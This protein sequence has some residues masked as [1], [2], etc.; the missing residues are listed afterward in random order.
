MR[1]ARPS[2]ASLP[3]RS[4]LTLTFALV[5]MSAT[6]AVSTTTFLLAKQYLVEQRERAAIRQTFLNARL[7]RDLLQTG[8]QEPQAILDDTVGE[9]GT[10]ALL[11]FDDQWFASGVAADP[12]DLPADLLDALDNGAA[13]HQRITRAG[14]PRVVIGVP[15]SA[16]NAEYLEIIPLDVLQ[17]TFRTLVIS[18]LIGSIGTTLA[19]TLVGVYVSQRVL[20][21]VKKM[22][23]VA[24]GI[25]EGDL[26]ARLDARGD[27]DLD[28]LVASFNEMVDALQTRIE[29]EQ[30]FASDVSHELRT[31]LTA[32]KAAIELVEQR[33]LD[34]PPRSRDALVMLARQVTYFERLVLDLLE[35]SRFDSG[36][37]QPDLEDT[38]VVEFLTAYSREHGGPSV[39]TDSRTPIRTG[40]DRRRMERILGNLLENADRY[41]GGATAI[42]VDASEHAVTI[43]INDSGNG[44]TADEREHIF[45]RFWRGR[46]ARHQASKGSGL[47]LSL[48]AEH[49]R[50]LGG[51]IRIEDGPGGGAR[52]VIDL[53]LETGW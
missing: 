9:A 26:R 7:V 22:S 13:A 14:K 6:L 28:P 2:P 50:V 12:S 24:A 42:T 37:E 5:T 3:L 25:T 19:G 36:V 43:S 49:V 15:L 52:F 32:L 34:L 44:I 48:V 8:G 16:A 39:I 11:R 29:R 23:A 30:R 18:L 38:D 46:D 10:L 4:R 51:N 31:P 45:E 20:R 17:R 40:V 53:P 33:S 21:P 47:G 27:R 41:A 35:I 1:A